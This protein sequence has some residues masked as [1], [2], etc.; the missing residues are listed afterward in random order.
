MMIE[1][2]MSCVAA[3]A[4]MG[5]WSDGIRFWALPN[6]SLQGDAMV[7][8]LLEKMGVRIIASPTDFPPGFVNVRVEKVKTFQGIEVD[9]KSTPDLFPVLAAFCSLAKSTT[10]IT[11]L[12]N[13]NSKESRR[14]DRMRELLVGL[15]VRCESSPGEFIIHP[16]EKFSGD[17]K[18]FTPDEDHRLAMAAALL[19]LRGAK[20][21]IQN[22]DVVQKS[23]PN[24]WQIYKVF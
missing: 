24:F 1:P 18:N 7:F 5:A 9:L 21:K 23:F 10:R 3:L 6:G 8:P 15:G 11:G 17:E 4:F 12:Q 2:D 16:V 20:L 13:L 22:P 14:L 19:N